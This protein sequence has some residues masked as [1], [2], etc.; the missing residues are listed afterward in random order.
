MTN[1]WEKYTPVEENPWERYS[2]EQSS[3]RAKLAESV[4]SEA[5]IYKPSYAEALQTGGI[6]GKGGVADVL[7]QGIV[8]GIEKYPEMLANT[9]KSIG[10]MLSNLVTPSQYKSITENPIV[11]L[12][13]QIGA[14]LITGITEPLISPRTTG[15]AAAQIGIDTALGTTAIKGVQAAKAAAPKGAQ[16]IMQSLVKPSKGELEFSKNPASAALREKITGNSLEDFQAKAIAKKEEILGAVDRRLAQSTKTIGVNDI[17]S[18]LDDEVNR[19]KSSVGITNKEQ[20]L[21]KIEQIQTEI[22]D[23]FPGSTN[24][25]LQDA[26]A[27]RREIDNSIPKF[28]ADAVEQGVNKAKFELRQKLNRLIDSQEPGV[29][30][31]N[32]RASEMIGLDH[33]LERRIRQSQNAPLLSQLGLAGEVAG[34]V[35]GYPGAATA[36]NLAISEGLGSA[37]VKTRGA[38]LL[39][40]I[41]GGAVEAPIAP[42]TSTAVRPSMGLIPDEM[43]AKGTFSESEFEL[44]GE[45][46]KYTGP[47]PK[48]LPRAQGTIREEEF[49]WPAEAKFSKGWFKA[50]KPV[51]NL[52]PDVIGYNPHRGKIVLS[53]AAMD[54]I[55]RLI[56]AKALGGISV[57]AG[58]EVSGRGAAGREFLKQLK[59][60]LPKELAM[61]PSNK[62]LIIQRVDPIRERYKE[63][64]RHEG[65]H[66][67]LAKVSGE[68][69][70]IEPQRF[71]AEGRMLYKFAE[72]KRSNYKPS[73]RAEEILAE[74]ATGNPDRIG[75]SRVE[76]LQLLH[77]M[78]EQMETKL[79][80]KGME[81]VMKR[82]APRFKDSWNETIK[83]LNLP[84]N[85]EVVHRGQHDMGSG[86]GN[87]DMF[88]INV[89]GGPKNITFYLKKGDDLA[90]KVKSTADNWKI[91]LQRK[92]GE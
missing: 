65:L 48:Q 45:A 16:R 38:Q 55:A 1:P 21:S 72:Q 89:K 83:S 92:G 24:I 25:S 11:D 77:E 60:E 57:A 35:L 58:T 31:L 80:Q 85:I 67:Q 63:V 23:R 14:G 68:D 19:L 56:G 44:P 64:A 81:T 91:D 49:N 5:S 8:E 15:E 53:D 29:Q 87:F 42:V 26:A 51:N 10:G 36:A 22:L 4:K 32:R 52:K 61:I 86:F 28:T 27:L 33:A 76:G 34:S 2:A 18:L 7:G 75:L 74:L 79:G 12:P 73:V 39:H 84:D 6:V 46:P 47:E 70:K 20:I 3:L 43:E 54:K 9:V 71:S 69:L 59:K 88:D 13:G 17:T 62:P 37:A 41:G 40:R 90:S 78:L 82:F 66:E 30:T 50:V